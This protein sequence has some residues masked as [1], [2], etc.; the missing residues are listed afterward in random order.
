MRLCIHSAE[1]F[2]A[3]NCG[4]DSW[5][6]LLQFSIT[7]LSVAV[8]MD[9]KEMIVSGLCWIQCA[10]AFPHLPEQYCANA[11]MLNADALIKAYVVWSRL[12]HMIECISRS[13]VFVHASPPPLSSL[14]LNG[15][16]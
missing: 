16:H 7:L 1:H 2:S 3:C 10:S 11:R 15:Y 14:T 12:N 4:E 6:V 8:V 9:N 13:A 5:G